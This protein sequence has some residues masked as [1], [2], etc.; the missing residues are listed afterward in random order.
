MWAINEL[1]LEF[2]R[3]DYGH[4]YIA[5]NTPEYLSLNPMGRVPVIRDGNLVMYESAAI[6][7]Y[8]GSEYGDEVFWPR[9]A[10]IRGRLDAI[11]EWG[12]NTF[13]E[14]VLKV[15]VYHVRM[16]PDTRDPAF[17]ANAVENL[18][19]LAAIFEGLLVGKEWLAGDHFTFADIACGHILHRYFS[20]DWE[21]P[22]LPCLLEYYHKLQS[23]ASYRENAM[24]PY[25]DLIGS[26]RPIVA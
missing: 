4:G 3:L 14:A 17:L 5:T 15:F 8:L 1:N 11:A 6:L 10:R 2:E 24:V 18:K 16:S 25:D 23:R 21:R 9:S 19:P 7:R 26:Y 20:L 22:E 13:A 12:K